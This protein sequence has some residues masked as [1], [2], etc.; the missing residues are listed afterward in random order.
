MVLRDGLA[1][2][3]VG[4]AV[5]IPAAL[6]AA[7]GSRTL[8]DEL[9]FGLEPTDLLVARVAV[10]PLLVVALPAALLPARP[11]SRV[12]PV[13]ALQAGVAVG[14]GRA[15]ERLR[16]EVM[17]TARRPSCLLVSGCSSLQA[18]TGGIR[19]IYSADP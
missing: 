18:A 4:L 3:G 8:L 16:T 9:L 12:H 17:R 13:V 14:G 6:A 19:R 10:A 15:D 5:G 2:A 11:A 1:M 7:R